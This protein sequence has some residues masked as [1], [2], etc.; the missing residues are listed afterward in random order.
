MSESVYNVQFWVENPDN[1][2]EFCFQGYAGCWEN[3]RSMQ[4]A[5]ALHGIEALILK[6]Y[7]GE[8]DDVGNDEDPYTGIPEREYLEESEKEIEARQAAELDRAEQEAYEQAGYADAAD[9]LP[10][11]EEV[12]VE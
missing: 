3:A 8:T 4:R 9:E 11:R 1:G 12:D 10:D 7:D 2:D 5:L 6:K